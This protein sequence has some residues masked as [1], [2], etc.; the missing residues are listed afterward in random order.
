MIAQRPI[1]AIRIQNR[2]K[3]LADYQTELHALRVEN[4]R[5]REALERISAVGESEADTTH[6]DAVNS[7]VEMGNLARAALN[8]RE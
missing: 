1:D 8:P 2:D 4:Q 7:I 5:L 6:D 3:R